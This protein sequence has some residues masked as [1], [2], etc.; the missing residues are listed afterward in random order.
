MQKPT[1]LLLFL[2]L[3]L[4]SCS[5]NI[6]EFV[7]NDVSVVYSELQ[8]IVP[9]SSSSFDLNNNVD[10]K[11]NTTKDLEIEIPTNTFK[12][13]SETN[14]IPF[15]LDVIEIDS[16]VGFITNNITHLSDDGIRDV[17]F[18]LYI[19]AKDNEDTNLELREDKDITIRIP[20]ERYT[21]MMEI[22]TGFVSE[23]SIAWDYSSSTTI[24]YTQWIKV[25]EDNSTDIISGYE[26]KVKETGWYTLSVINDVPFEL[27]DIC[28][29]IEESK[30]N[31]S[32]TL[33]YTLLDSYQ[34]LLQAQ[35]ISSENY[36]NYNLPV[37]GNTLKIISISYL[38]DE[39]QFYYDSKTIETQDLNGMIE[40]DPSEIDEESLL[41]KLY[42]L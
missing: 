8:Q 39:D 18:S 5:D 28:M 9:S 36:C 40:L 17:I 16:Y 4:F 15:Q 3:I 6:D 33:V 41:S 30:L 14:D 20:S 12:S 10:S 29:T 2:C 7:P 31:E 11:I 27:I 23:N 26:F 13:Q 24:D 38:E 1:G 35:S 19:S 37:T 42:S 25:N 22:G 34:Y 32:N 21:G